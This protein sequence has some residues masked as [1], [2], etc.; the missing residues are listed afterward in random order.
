MRWLNFNG[1]NARGFFNLFAK[2]PNRTF[3]TQLAAGNGGVLMAGFFLEPTTESKTATRFSTLFEALAAV[4]KDNLVSSNQAEMACAYFLGGRFI[5]FDF[6]GNCYESTNGV[7]FTAGINPNGDFPGGPYQ[8]ALDDTNNTIVFSG[9]ND[10]TS[11]YVS[12]NVTP[13]NF[14][15]AVE[16]DAGNIGAIANRPGSGVLLLLGGG[17]NGGTNT[18]VWRSTDG[19]M[20]WALVGLQPFVNCGEFL[21]YGTTQWIAQGSTSSSNVQFS[22]ST[23]DGATWTAATN[24]PGPNNGAVSA[25]QATDGAGNWVAIGDSDPPDNYWVSS[26]DGTTWTSPNLFDASKQDGSVQGLLVWDGHKWC[27]CWNNPDDSALF[28]SVSTDGGATWDVGP[29]IIDQ[30]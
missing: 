14:S 19:G 12:D 3:A 17:R 15:T 9:S 20:T 4:V 18:N 25:A 5:A 21:G 26:D 10:S 2:Q 8:L 16:V 24:F 22:L 11:V 1:I 13:L 7:D 30:P 23:D 6:D 27:A 28:V 29:T